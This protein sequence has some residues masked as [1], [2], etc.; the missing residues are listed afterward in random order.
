[1]NDKTDLSDDFSIVLGILKAYEITL[2][3]IARTLTDEQEKQMAYAFNRL[4][5][6]VIRGYE[7][8]NS[9]KTERAGFN[10]MIELIGER[11]HIKP[12]DVSAI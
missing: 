4:R 3:A 11:L 12:D 6:D 5:Q 1:M 10:R 8:D 9:L 2:Y 7:S